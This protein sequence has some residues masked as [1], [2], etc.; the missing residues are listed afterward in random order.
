M[1]TRADAHVVVTEHG[2][3]WMYGR[4]LRQRAQALIEIAD[5][6]FREE[7]LRAA[8]ERQLF[9]RLSPGADLGGDSS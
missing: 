8:H 4:N 9:G 3:A 7:L 1:T 2:L 6:R 5:P